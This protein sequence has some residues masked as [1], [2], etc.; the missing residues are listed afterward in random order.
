MA[1]EKA[2][3]CDCL[4]QISKIMADFLNTQFDTNKQKVG[5]INYFLVIFEGKQA[6]FD[7]YF[8]IT[9]H[10]REF[11]KGMKQ[12][13]VFLQHLNQEG[14]DDLYELVTE[15]VG[16]DLDPAYKEKK[17]NGDKKSNENREH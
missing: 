10:G 15:K 17:K 5:F 8:N 13:A 4:Q 12:H 3:S 9:E 1:S 11:A 7:A 6:L 14:T 16:V 2:H